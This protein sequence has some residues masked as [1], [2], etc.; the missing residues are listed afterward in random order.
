MICFL[1]SGKSCRLRWLNHLDPRVNQSPFTEEEEELLLASQRVYGNRW[2][3]IARLFPGRT[4]NAVKNRWH[5]IMVRRH[6]QGMRE[7][8]DKRATTA[9]D[10]T[11]ERVSHQSSKEGYCTSTTDGELI[12][13][14]LACI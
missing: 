9:G 8:S 13:Q 3:D 12:N 14:S 4:D 10:T 5:V 6:S 2:A 1:N 7:S 11:A